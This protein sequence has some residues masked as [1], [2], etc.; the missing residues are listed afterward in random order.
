[1]TPTW[2]GQAWPKK[3][4]G[5]FCIE[6]IPLSSLYLFASN[7]RVHSCLSFHLFINPASRRIFTA[8]NLQKGQGSSSPTLE[9][10]AHARIKS[11][12]KPWHHQHGAV[13]NW[14][15]TAGI[16]LTDYNWGLLL[17]Q[18]QRWI[19]KGQLIIWKAFWENCP[20]PVAMTHKSYTQSK[21]WSGAF[22]P[23][24]QTW[25]LISCNLHPLWLLKWAHGPLSALLI[26]I[27]ATSSK[28]LNTISE[29]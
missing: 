20:S 28:E 16:V 27:H 18:A 5:E 17:F 23:N 26:R 22:C 8:G 25:N 6:V 7:F 10:M 1:M 2:K 24:N 15:N 3:C 29:I 19:S 4:A 21:C 13:T 11:P 9:W 12:L 14:A